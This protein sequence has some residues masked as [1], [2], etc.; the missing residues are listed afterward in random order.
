MY[1]P[2]FRGGPSK[3]KSD[4]TIRGKKYQ[5]PIRDT[6][7]PRQKWGTRETRLLIISASKSTFLFHSFHLDKVKKIFISRPLSSLDL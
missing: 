7:R 5:A 2:G 4:I 3:A 1:V 6:N